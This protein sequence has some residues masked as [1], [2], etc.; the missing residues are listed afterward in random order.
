M[1]RHQREI[2]CAVCL[3]LGLAPRALA[4]EVF[5]VWATGNVQET[6]DVDNGTV[7]W[8]DSRGHTRYYL[9]YLA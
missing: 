8:E 3:T 9:L 4:F 7:A 2:L 6:P 1:M 5:P